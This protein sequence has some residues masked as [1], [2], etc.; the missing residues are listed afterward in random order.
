MNASALLMPRPRPASAWVLPVGGAAVLAAALAGLS[1]GAVAVPP[2][3]VVRSLAHAAGLP[4]SAP[5]DPLHAAVVLSLRLPRVLLGLLVGASLAVSGV[6]VQGWF[7][8]PLAEPTLLGVSGGASL[9]AASAIVLTDGLTGPVAVPA[10][11]FAGGL[12][13]VLVVQALG[14]ARAH[15]D[16]TTL[17]LAG[18]AVTSLCGAGTGLLVTV[19]DDDDL[20]DIAF[21][22]LGS[23]GGATWEQ[24]SWTLPSLAI[25]LALAT[26]L[27]RRL[28]ALLLGDVTAAHL[29][30]DVPGT[31]RQIAA[32]VAA[33][34]GV[35][36]AATGLIGFL[37]LVG[38]HLVRMVTGPR[39][40][41]LLPA[42]ALVGAALLAT[43]DVI[44]RTV[45]SPV[46]LPIGVLTTLLGAP[47]FLVLLSTRREGLS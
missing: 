20:R 10:A 8:N 45:V 35:S 24:L 7:R 43:A 4:V 14:S 13:A 15:A 34:V 17:L 37:G 42:A 30:V 16:A 39:H 29:G 21:W 33:L 11:A 27:A 38:P 40:A 1:L 26:R 23:V 31:Q 9:A 41:L 28:D 5:V 22:S 25:G 46:E 18:L 12:V 2:E 3:D 32:L 47:L 36:V 19:A 44:A 6:L